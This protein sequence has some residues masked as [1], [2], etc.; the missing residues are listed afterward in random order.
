MFPSDICG[1]T[2]SVKELQEIIQRSLSEIEEPLIGDL[3]YFSENA[4]YEPDSLQIV[5]ITQTN[6]SQYSMSYRYKW[7]VFNGCLD[8]NADEYTTQNVTFRVK[9]EGLEF[10]IIDT[11]RGT[12]ADEL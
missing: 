2:P 5:S 8:I 6:E 7:T 11:S 12:T 9:P 3:S 1:K 10:D 4:R